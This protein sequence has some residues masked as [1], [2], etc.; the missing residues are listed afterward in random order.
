M[1]RNKRASKI[2]DFNRGDNEGTGYFHVNQRRGWRWSTAKGFLR[3]AQGRKNLKI[4]THAQVKQLTLEGKRVT[5]A[6]L[7]LGDDDATISCRRELILAT[8]SVGSPQILRCQGLV[9]PIN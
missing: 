4:F 5:G 6:A 1:R 9:H 8:G 7:R 2:K 3:P